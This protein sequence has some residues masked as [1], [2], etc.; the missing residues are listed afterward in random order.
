[1]NKFYNS[2]LDRALV[3][4]SYLPH[5][6]GQGFIIDRILPRLEPPSN[7]LRPRTRFGIRFECDLTDKLIREIYYYGFDRRD[8]RVLSR[9]VES[10]QVVLDIGA[11][12]GY[13]SLLFAKWVG[14]TGSSR[15]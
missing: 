9:L 2:I 5:H 1:M 14:A 4:Y 15:H 6:P 13:F 8:C 10:G 3:A 7:R 12:I 11:N